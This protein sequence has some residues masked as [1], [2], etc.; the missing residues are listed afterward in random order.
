MRK[1]SPFSNSDVTYQNCVN[2]NGIVTSCEDTHMP[3]GRQ[4]PSE[5]ATFTSCVFLRLNSAVNGSAISFTSS[6]TL[7]ISYS[8][9]EQC[10]SS[11]GVHV[12][13]GGGAVCVDNGNLFVYFSIFLCCSTSCY[14]GCILAQTSCVSSSVL[15]CMFITCDALYGGGLMTYWGPTS[16]VSSSR[17]ISSHATKTGGGL[18]H[19]SDKDTSWILLSDSLFTGNCA[20]WSP[21][22]GGGAFEDY[23]Y[24]SYESDYHFLFFSG[25]T[26]PYGKG[27]DICIAGSPVEIKS[28]IHCFTTVTSNSIWNV[29]G[30]MHNWRPLGEM[31]YPTPA[32]INESYH[33]RKLC[34][35]FFLSH[36]FH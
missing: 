21:N 14:G 24:H 33:H 19:D 30:H 23:R 5:S 13:Y 34:H 18:Y 7:R 22:R 25:N 29:D 9:F 12:Y 31:P 10:S 35:H 3:G 36:V 1:R 4:T 11:V 27:C 2:D 6:G 32:Q 8:S 20:D 15:S 28:I 17:F 16:F 26:A